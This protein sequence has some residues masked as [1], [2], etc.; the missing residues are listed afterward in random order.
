M[1]CARGGGCVAR[2]ILRTVH[3]VGG[4]NH[5]Q[6][7][8]TTD[9]DDAAGDIPAHSIDS[10]GTRVVVGAR[11]T[12]NGHLRVA[13][14]SD[15]GRCLVRAIHGAEAALATDLR[16]ASAG[17]VARR[18][19]HARLA[20]AGDCAHGS[21][22]CERV[23]QCSGDGNCHVGKH[24]NIDKD[25]HS[26]ARTAKHEH[27]LSHAP[28][29]TLI[30]LGSTRPSPVRTDVKPPAGTPIVKVPSLGSVTANEMVV[31]STLATLVTVP[32]DAENVDATGVS[33][34]ASDSVNRANTGLE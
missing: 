10:R 11:T 16:R 33:T 28:I 27:M 14:Q 5:G 20:R 18:A 7:K 15:D 3:D 1:D 2:S 32:D 8:R 4:T 9:G 34:T 12:L 23:H 13:N 19:T 6:I 21:I 24:S 25:T 26:H 22:V 31:A 17:E 30:G 29:V